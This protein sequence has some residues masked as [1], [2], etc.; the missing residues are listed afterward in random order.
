[1]QRRTFLLTAGAAIAGVAGCSR[2]TSEDPESAGGTPTTTPTP[3]SSPTA[4]ADVSITFDSLQSGIVTPDSPDSIAVTPTSGQYLYLS[5]TADGDDPPAPEKFAFAFDGSEYSPM[6]IS[7]QWRKKPWRAH[8]ELPYG[9][10]SADE[11]WLLFDLPESGSASDAALRYPGGEWQP[12]D[13]LTERLAT[14]TPPFEVSLDAP[15]A[16]TEEDPWMTVTVENKGDV[17]GGFIGA[18]NRVGPKI[19]YAPVARVPLTVPA[20]GQEQWKWT[21]TNVPTDDPDAA[22]DSVRLKFNW[23]GGRLDRAIDLPGDESNS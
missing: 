6:A 9:E 20:G 5:V 7:E 15:E 17:P 3:T 12:G 13:T 1:M 14:P 8:S 16:V 18:L 21:G 23:E 10:E 4:T 22:Y 2:S 11:G 19:A